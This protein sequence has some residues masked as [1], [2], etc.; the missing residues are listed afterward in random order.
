[1]YKS[2]FISPYFVF[3]V[4]NYSANSHSISE[5]VVELDKLVM[6]MLFESYGVEGYYDS[7][8]GSLNYLLRYFK[9]RAPE[10]N[11]T[12][13]GLTPHTDKTVTSII[14]QINHVNGLQVQM[15]GGEWI[16]VEPSPSSYIVMA[17]DALMVSMLYFFISA[18]NQCNWDRMMTYNV[19]LFFN[20][21]AW[22]NDRIP[23]CRHQVIM[24]ESETRY[25]L[26]LFSFSNG[27]VDIPKELG[28]E[29][30]PLKY[31]SFDHFGFLYFNQSEEGKKSACSIKAYCGI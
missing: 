1:M 26:G 22:S 28:D 18:I 4:Q 14:H 10:K 31:K 7:Y 13:M 5:L 8:I 2:T 17:G 15:K 27:E 16:D 21:Q 3:C 12:T 23:P 20:S 25:S 30:R 19:Q 6:R 9:Y 11:E 29:K 24:N